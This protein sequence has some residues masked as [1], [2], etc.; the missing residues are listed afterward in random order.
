MSIRHT[1]LNWEDFIMVNRELSENAKG[2][3][4]EN[5]ADLVGIINAIDLPEHAEDITRILPQAKSVIVV[6]AKHSLAAIQSG[7]IQMGQFDTIHAY[8]ECSKAAHQTTRFLESMLFPSVAVPAFIPID[9]QAPKKGMRGEICW[10][11]AGVRA[12][13]GSYGENGLLVTKAFGSAVRLAGLVTAADLEADDPL[14]EDVCDHC[15][16]CIDACPVQALSAEGKIDKRK[17]GDEIFKYGFRFFAGFMRD[18]IAKP[19]SETQD[20]LRGHGLRE[21]WQT[22]MT[23]NYYYCFECQAQC[24]AMRLPQNNR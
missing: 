9:M 14:G 13:L 10:R 24:P 7:N 6:A 2:I 21:L 15:L 1:K 23:G 3:A 18:L 20:M 19:K 8:D 5:G 4:L 12:G 16:R 11:R 17:C 22:F